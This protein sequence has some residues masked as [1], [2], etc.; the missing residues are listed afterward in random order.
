M[1]VLSLFDGISCG[2]VALDSAGIHVDKYFASEVDKYAIST[3]KKNWPDILQLGDVRDICAYDL[4]KIDLLLAGSPC[5]GFSL[6]GNQNNF[7]DSRS[8][9]FWEFVRIKNET[10]PECFLLENV[11]MDKTSVNVISEAVGCEP[12]KINSRM[13]SAQNRNRLYWT[14]IPFDRNITD[15]KLFLI[16]VWNGGIDITDRYLSKKHGTLSYK[17]SRKQTCTLYDKSFVLTTDGINRISKSG[18]TN[19]KIGEKY[20]APDP[21]TCERLQTLPDNYTAGVSNTQRYK[22]L[23][24]GW[25]VEVIAHILDGMGG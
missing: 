11:R 4:P 20:F 13:L 9:L 8:A 17:K 14:N 3:S 24:N 12:V 2:R 23:G 7:N 19:V 16:D 5:Q 18:S 15:R 25:T 6:A 22:Q 1:N 10:N 21:V